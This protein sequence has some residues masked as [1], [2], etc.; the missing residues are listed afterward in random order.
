MDVSGTS[1]WLIYSPTSS[2]RV[3]FISNPSDWT[4]VGKT[5]RVVGTEASGKKSKR[6]DW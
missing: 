1:S 4:G 5:G 2:Y 3:R 6:M